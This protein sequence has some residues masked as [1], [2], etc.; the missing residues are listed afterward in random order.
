M[1]A[2][3]LI[4]RSVAYTPMRVSRPTAMV[5]GV[6]LA[7]PLLT[8]RSFASAEP[9]APADYKNVK[10]FAKEIIQEGSGPL[11]KIGQMCEGWPLSVR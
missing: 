8:V 5:I 10:G 2:A 1:R 4:G 11:P 9:R 7:T 6:A 3:R